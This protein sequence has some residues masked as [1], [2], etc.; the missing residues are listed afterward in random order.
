MASKTRAKHSKSSL[1]LK[2]AQESQG[3]LSRLDQS[4]YHSKDVHVSCH[5]YLQLDVTLQ[6]SI[7]ELLEYNMKKY[8]EKSEWGW[9]ASNKIKEL[10]HKNSWILLANDVNTQQFCGFVN[11]RFDIGSDHSEAVVYCYELQIEESFQ[12]KG[13]GKF[14]MK[15][16]E[17]IAVQFKMD[18]VMLTVFKQNSK[19]C[20]FYMNSLQFRIDKS[21]PSKFG[22][23]KD[24]EILSKKVTKKKV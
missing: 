22:Q 5:R 17:E 14:M 10:S 8:Y 21:S 16:L 11:F 23:E 6:Q 19:A 20:N 15:I 12:G 13:I 9:S 4:S 24:Y 7:I 1:F 3:P 18:K 2:L